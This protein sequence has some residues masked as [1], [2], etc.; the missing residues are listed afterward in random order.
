MSGSRNKKIRKKIYGQMAHRDTKYAV[1]SH[2]IAGWDKKG[3]PTKIRRDTILCR[4]L[5]EEYQ[6]AK[7]DKA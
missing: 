5:R 2:I 1:E 7:K 4:D 3:K 6:K